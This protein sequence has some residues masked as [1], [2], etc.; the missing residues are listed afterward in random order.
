VLVFKGYEGATSNT[1]QIAIF[2]LRNNS[3][4]TIWLCY[5]GTEYPLRA[6]FLEEPISVRKETNVYR[7][8]LGSFF[9]HGEKVLPGKDL[10]LEFPLIYG[11]PAER[12]GIS[13]YVGSFKDGTDFL[14]SLRRPLPSS[15]T[16]A[17]KIAFCWNNSKRR[18]SAPKRYEVWCPEPVSF[19]ASTSNTTALPG[20]NPEP[21]QTR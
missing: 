3:R 19:Q 5:T 2:Q 7:I 12:V 8:S 14:G 1:A 18:I 9:M 17:G 6:P 15:A 10:A 20:T 13:Y 21:S 4:R 11:N 16:L